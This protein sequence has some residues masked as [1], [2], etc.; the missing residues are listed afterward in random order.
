MEIV[1]VKVRPSYGDRKL[2]VLRFLFPDD[3]FSV[4]LVDTK[5]RELFPYGFFK[6]SYERYMIDYSYLFGRSELVSV[7]NH[8]YLAQYLT[9]NKDL[10]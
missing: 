9:S 10:K 8:E 2:H 5:L 1:K 6:P 4:S 3:T 7:C